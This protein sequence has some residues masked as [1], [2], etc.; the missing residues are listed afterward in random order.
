MF[1]FVIDHVPF[2]RKDPYFRLCTLNFNGLQSFTVKVMK[3]NIYALTSKITEI[4][5]K[6]KYLISPQQSRNYLPKLML[7]NILSGGQQVTPLAALNVPDQNI[8]LLK[9][10]LYHVNEFLIFLTN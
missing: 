2:E 4:T 7:A 3:K 8:Y 6:S 1:K 10:I 5:I 9:K